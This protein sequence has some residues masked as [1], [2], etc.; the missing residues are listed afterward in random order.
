MFGLRKNLFPLLISPLVVI[1]CQRATSQD[2]PVD[3]TTVEKEQTE[4]LAPVS[5]IELKERLYME[6]KEAMKDFKKALET[7]D[8]KIAK[9][10]RNIQQN[11]PEISHNIKEAWKEDAEGLRL[12]RDK[13]LDEFKKLEGSTPE[14]WHKLQASFCDRWA[15]LKER[16]NG[17]QAE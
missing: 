4:R 3:A 7:L 13:L 2:L 17:K 11:S 1:G 14:N 10:E 9:L 16:W 6:K 12:Q 8:L 15:S 5:F